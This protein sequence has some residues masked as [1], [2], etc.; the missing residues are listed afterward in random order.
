MAALAQRS[1]A[2]STLTPAQVA[3]QAAITAGTLNPTVAN[4]NAAAAAATTGIQA[5]DATI[6]GLQPQLDALTAQATALAGTPAAGAPTVS[7]AAYQGADGYWYYPM[8]DGST[9]KGALGQSTVKPGGGGDPGALQIITDTL[10][11]AGLG[12]LAGNALS[13]WNK[14]FNINAIMDDPTNGIR[15]S[16]AY[17]QR[18][19]GMAALNAAGHGITEGEYIAKETTDRGLLYQ[20]LG[21]A[22]K[23]FDTT[24]N[25]GAIISG[26]KSSTELQSDLQAAHDVVNA[27]PET[28]TWLKN[29]YGLSQG[30]LAAYWL[31]PD[32]ASTDITRRA[33]AGQLAGISHQS[34]FG[35]L[36]QIQAEGLAN[37][38]VT[39]GQAHNVF[40]QIGQEG[41][42]MRN[43]P[44]DTS[45]AL[46]QQQMLDAAFNGG[47]ALTML[48]RVRG[49]RVAGFQDGGQFAADSKGLVGLTSA[50]TL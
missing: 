18:F 32:I 47:D 24:A 15:A 41:E 13:M 20:Y 26:F 29:T 8:S 48:N 46:T 11:Q 49:Q 28:A 42:F 25:L 7:G 4:K 1:S 6:T 19:P 43:L 40:G 35:D 34:G 50:S 44:G 30:D 21:D 36:S 22:A 16:Q 31:N 37:Q 2:P 17:K 3:A 39:P 10:N 33:Q 14:G 9:M 23:P 27:S 38:G 12:S 45:G 5:T